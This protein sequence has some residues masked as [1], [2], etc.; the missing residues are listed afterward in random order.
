[1]AYEEAFEGL[2]LSGV[3]ALMHGDS[4][5]G[6]WHYPVGIN[7]REYKPNFPGPLQYVNITDVQL[8]IK[9]TC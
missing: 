9:K 8:Y 7:S 5:A 3:E 1:M 6:F 2:K 4:R